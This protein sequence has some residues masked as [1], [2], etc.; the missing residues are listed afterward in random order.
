VVTDLPF[1][2]ALGI[3][4]FAFLVVRIYFLRRARILRDGWFSRREGRGNGL[5]LL[6]SLGVGVVLGVRIFAPAALAWSAVYLPAWLRWFG[7]ALGGAGLFLLTWSQALLAENFSPTLRV[8]DDHRLITHGPY[9]TIRH[10]I[11]T[12]F[13][14]LFAGFFLLSADGLIG[15]LGLGVIAYLLA[16]TPREEAMMLESFGDDYR[17]YMEQTG[18]YFPRWRL[19]R[20]LDGPA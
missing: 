14:L 20:T 7:N 5:R 15:V 11:Y 10:P 16:R 8:R 2:L 6:L 9:R 18:R 13:L 19:V 17:R 12:A 4:V 3:L 1:R